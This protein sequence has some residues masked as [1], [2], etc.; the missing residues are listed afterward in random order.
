LARTSF[1]HFDD[2]CA[3]M[4]GIV[5]AWR[6]D[7]L[8]CYTWAAFRANL[9]VTRMLVML[10][11]VAGAGTL[12]ERDQGTLLPTAVLAICSFVPSNRRP[13]IVLA[14]DSPFR[15]TSSPATCGSVSS[16]SWNNFDRLVLHIEPIDHVTIFESC[17]D[18]VDGLML[19]ASKAFLQRKQW[20]RQ[21]SKP[22]TVVRALDVTV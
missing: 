20:K 15:P 18:S 4:R 2:V 21:R 14:R 19:L 16:T 5:D 12:V 17:S 7:D 11:A 13:P 9:M 8:Q 3:F 10:V 1:R 6:L 22:E